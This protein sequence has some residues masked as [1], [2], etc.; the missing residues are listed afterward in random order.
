MTQVEQ[1]IHLDPTYAPAWTSL[2]AV[3]FHGGQ[4]EL[5]GKAFRKAVELTPASAD[6]RLALANYEWATGDT[7]AAEAS[8]RMTLEM[9]PANTGA[10]RALALLYLTTRRARLAEPHFQALAA[11]PRGK[12]ALADFYSG[13][14]QTAEAKAVLDE[15]AQSDN[16][17]DRRAAQLRLASLE[18][19]AG[20]TA[21][22]HRIVD[23][24]LTEHPRDVAA[25]NARA[26]MLLKGGAVKEAAAEA[27]TAIKFDAGSTDAHYTLGLAAV[28]LQNYEEATRELQKVVELNPRASAAQMQLARLQLAAGENGRAL[29]AAEKAVEANPDDPA[30]AA[31]VARSLRAQGQLATAQQQLVARIKRQPDTVL[32]TELGWVLLDQR[33]IAA[34]RQSFGAALRLAPD[35]IEARTGLVTADLAD[36]KTA[37]AQAQLD[38]WLRASPAD[39]RL[40]VLSA[41]LAIASG[42]SADAEGVLRDIISSDPAHL[43]AYELARPLVRCSRRPGSRQNGI[44]GALRPLPCFRRGHEPCRR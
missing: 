7:K 30:A 15:L 39:V 12:L 26:R 32:H 23:E 8:L 3:R 28:A 44:P 25:R 38:E 29:S 18:Y 5:A 22:A 27:R 40:R 13:T 42:R 43:E 20:R 37:R 19:A 35:S 9:E 34:A 21:N 33:D 36:G 1:A 6:A 31:L 16:K 2:G 24:I 17:S 14:N 11:D 4:R 10:H 41:R